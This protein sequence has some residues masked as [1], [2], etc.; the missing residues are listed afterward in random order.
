[1]LLFVSTELQN[2]P[3]PH[4]VL[5]Q[6]FSESMKGTFEKCIKL[7]GNSSLSL[8]T[9]TSY[10]LSLTVPQNLSST[11]VQKENHEGN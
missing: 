4:F 7:S 6:D 2:I 9:S 10:K 8:L 5:G 1:M 3:W 11:S